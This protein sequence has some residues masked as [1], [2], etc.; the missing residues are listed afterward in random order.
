MIKQFIDDKDEKKIAKILNK[1]PA[2]HQQMLGQIL[3]GYD[4]GG[5]DE[6]AHDIATVFNEDIELHNKMEE[7]RDSIEDVKRLSKDIGLSE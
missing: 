6:I 1:L 2:K 3:F 4:G 7:L 5:Y